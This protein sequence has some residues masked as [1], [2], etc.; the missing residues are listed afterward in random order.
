[1]T[2]AQIKSAERGKEFQKK[3]EAL[4]KKYGKNKEKLNE[5]MAKLQAKYLPGQ[6]GGCLPMIILI[7]FLIQ[8]RNVI[9]ALV[10]NGA[11]AFNEVAYPF[12]TK[13]ADGT[14]IN[15]HFLGMDLSK[16]ATDF[17]WSDSKII[18]YVILAV[19]VGFSQLISTQILSGI[20]SFGAKKEEKKKD[21]KKKK[22]KKEDDMPDMSAMMGMASKQMMFIFPIFTII[23]S[24]GYWG[25]GKVFPSGISVFWTVQSVFVIIQQLIMN[26]EKVLAWINIKILKKDEGQGTSKK[27]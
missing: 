10:E 4:K 15:L 23:T 1:M 6:I 21:T 18:P 11:A 13:F 14:V 25:G 2:K 24:L 9:R 16:V 22:K 3:Y 27:S 19:L 17:A 7:I 20:K 26:R 8:V 12:I 5:E